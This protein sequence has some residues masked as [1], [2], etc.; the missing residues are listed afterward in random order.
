V[1]WLLGAKGLS[2]PKRGTK[3][4]RRQFGNQY[5]IKNP[6]KEYLEILS[7]NSSYVVDINVAGLVCSMQ[8]EADEMLTDIKVRGVEQNG[9]LKR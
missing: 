7:L 3:A 4:L 6:K 9:G 8:K 5:K 2:V 1:R